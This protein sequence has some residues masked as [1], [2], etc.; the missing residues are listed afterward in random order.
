MEDVKV[1]GLLSTAALF[2]SASTLICCALPA[3]FVALGMGATFAGL[4]GAIPQLV[5]FSEHKTIIFPL[6]GVLLTANGVLRYRNRNA[7]CPID[8]RL[9]EACTR[10]R[11]GATWIFRISVAAYLV[12]AFF[13]FVAGNL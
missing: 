1:N 4:V 3:L 6:A 5:W 12:G 7:A 8:P 13:A 9:A 10:T 2:T 11:K